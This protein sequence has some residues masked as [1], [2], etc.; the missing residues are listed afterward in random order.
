MKRNS[1]IASRLM[2]F[3]VAIVLM[4]LMAVP[5]FA[6]AQCPPCPFCPP[7]P[8]VE[9]IIP[10]PP[11]AIPWS[12]AGA[13][14]EAAV[15][16]YAVTEDIVTEDTVTED[17]VTEEV[18]VVVEEAVTEEVE[19]VTVEVEAIEEVYVPAE[20]V[21]VTVIGTIDPPPAP[22]AVVIPEQVITVP[23]EPTVEAVEEP[24]PAP[25]RVNPPTSDQSSSNGMFAVLAGLG[26]VGIVALTVKD[27]MAKEGN[28]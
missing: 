1:K 15:E 5:A 21:I 6:N 20:E 3:A 11:P 4:V 7:C 25:R 14:V 10:D 9:I 17:T 19:A 8:P 23:E 13:S 18:V 27:K 22:V 24:A 28:R 26:L 16:E 2:A 12:P